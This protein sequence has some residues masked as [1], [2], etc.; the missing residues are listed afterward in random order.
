MSKRIP[1]SFIQTLLD[2]V[3]IVDVID[4]RVQLKKKGLNYSA[5]CPFH[6]EKTPSFSVSQAKQFFYCFGCGKNGNAITFLLEYDNIDFVDAVE[7]LAKA[8]GLE[9]P[10]EIVALQ[11][12]RDG[13]QSEL[14]AALDKAALFYQKQL[15]THEN[16]KAAIDYLK[17]RKLSGQTA[18]DFALGYAPEAWEALKKTYPTSSI[19]ALVSAGLVVKNDQGRTYDRFRN[20][21]IFPIRDR[22]GRTVGFGGRVMSPDEKPKYLNSPETPVF[23]KGELLYG[24]YEARKKNNQFEQALIVEGY[25]DVIALY[26]HGITYALAS[27]GTATSASHLKIVL[28]LTPKV[29]YCFDGDTAGKNAALRALDIAMPLLT[30]SEEIKFLFLPDGQDPDSMVQAHGKEAFLDSVEKATPLSEFLTQ[31][32]ITD[33]NLTSLEGRAQLVT[34]SLPYLKKM[35]ATHYLDMLIEKIA[36]LAQIDPIKIKRQLNSPQQPAGNATATPRKMMAHGPIEKALAFII[37]NPAQCHALPQKTLPETSDLRV[38]FNETT[39]FISKNQHI[40][41]AGIFEHFREHSLA[42]KIAELALVE[43]DLPMEATLKE[44]VDIVGKCAGE[45]T[46]IELASLTEKSKK[47]ALSNDEKQRLKQLLH[48]RIK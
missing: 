44:V 5:C 8:A 11:Q 30:G 15:R 40:T 22:R 1:Q 24:L 38:L 31:H 29:T 26:E 16:G 41:A 27:L 39:D 33:L 23:H 10:R 34:K 43:F 21:I 28:R 3:D 19:E 37:Q 4:A 42:S 36:K 25:M 7:D 47:H 13:D 45:N 32:L 9:V 2:R 17:S 18:K 48:A 6:H 35:Q 12:S 20:R 14:F 46:E